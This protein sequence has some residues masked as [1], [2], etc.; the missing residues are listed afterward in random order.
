MPGRG[1]MVADGD[2]RA[3]DPDSSVEGTTLENS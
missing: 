1:G 2:K 3:R